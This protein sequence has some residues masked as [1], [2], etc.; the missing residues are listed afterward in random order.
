M[1]IFIKSHFSNKPSRRG[2][3]FRRFSNRSYLQVVVL[4][5]P[6]WDSSS[7]LPMLECTNEESRFISLGHSLFA[8]CSSVM[9]SSRWVVI[10]LRIARLHLLT[11]ASFEGA[12]TLINL[13]DRDRGNRTSE[14]RKRRSGCLGLRCLFPFPD[15]S[16]PYRFLLQRSTWRRW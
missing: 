15:R 11:V 9:F 1:R 6:F 4:V 10:L 16:C 8:N 3:G 2:L 12:C 14:L 13:V 7:V 5:A